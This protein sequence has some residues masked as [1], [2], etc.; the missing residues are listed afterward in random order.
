MRLSPLIIYITLAGWGF[1]LS[2]EAPLP[3]GQDVKSPGEEATT[4]AE[5]PTTPKKYS[6]SDA[7]FPPVG[8]HVK[9]IR[10][11]RYKGTRLDA[12][13]TAYLVE[14]KTP[15]LL[16][17]DNIFIRLY[18]QD[19]QAIET[20]LSNALYDTESGLVRSSDSVNLVDPRFTLKGKDVLLDLNKK[21]LF[22][23]GPVTST[24]DAKLPI[25]NSP[26]NSPDKAPNHSTNNFTDT[27]TSSSTET[28][29]S[30]SPDELEP[31]S[32]STL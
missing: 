32:P 22:I 31:A 30:A 29:P 17:G 10:L 15:T 1:A 16:K 14:I 2:S 28:P 27:P 25:D 4:G 13:V 8:S 26:D 6:L 3:A 19:G 20:T 18:K 9:N 21:K 23:T 11:P 24:F 7:L 5:A 12:Y